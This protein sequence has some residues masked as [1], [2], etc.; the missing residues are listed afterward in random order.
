MKTKYDV[1][2]IGAG[3]SGASCAKILV[4][5]GLNILVIEEKKLP[6]FK[7]CSGMYSTRALNIIRKYYNEI[8]EKFWCKKNR[9][10]RFF[11]Q[12][13]SKSRQ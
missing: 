11:C 12:R 8:P 5:K 10:V 13:N 2:I 7:C 6:R 1:I 4:E 3:P 9:F